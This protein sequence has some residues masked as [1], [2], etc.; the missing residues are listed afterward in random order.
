[1]V[2]IAQEWLDEL[3]EQAT[4]DPKL[5]D[6]LLLIGELNDAISQGRPVNQHYDML[7]QQMLAAHAMVRVQEIGWFA[8][9]SD[10]GGSDAEPNP[11]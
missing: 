1:M 3:C 4:R 2:E 9:P 7:L 11:A 6:A 5:R 8:K 10:A